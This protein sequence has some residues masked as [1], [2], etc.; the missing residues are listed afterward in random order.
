MGHIIKTFPES[1][2]DIKSEIDAIL[3]SSEAS[4]TIIYEQL[5]YLEKQGIKIYCLYINY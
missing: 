5:S 4:E 1:I 2:E 3:I